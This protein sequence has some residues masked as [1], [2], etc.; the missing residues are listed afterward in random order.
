MEQKSKEVAVWL[1][2]D[3]AR[4]I[5]GAA[6]ANNPS[7]WAVQ[8]IIGDDT[9]LGFWLRANIIQEFRPITNGTKQITWRSTST[10]LLIRWDAVLTIQV[11]EGGGDDIGFKPVA[12]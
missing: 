11:F 10:E 4:A 6:P 5:V 7:R 1:R 3:H 12:Q 2:D 8:G 9:G